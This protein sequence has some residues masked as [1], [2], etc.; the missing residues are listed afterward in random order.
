MRSEAAAGRAAGVAAALGAVAIWAGWIPVTRLGVLTRL[1]PADVA[2]LRYGTA[3]LLL[4]PV[5]APRVRELPWRRPGPLLALLAGAGVPYFL[6]FAYGL[7][8]ANSGQ[9]G[10]LGPG[11]TSA[12]A[13]LLAW[14]L[15]GERPRPRRLAGLALTL[16]GIA[17]V[18]GHDLAAGGG[19]LLG[20][21][22]I[23]CASLGWAAYTVASRVLGLPPVLNAA[24]VAVANA[25][26]FLPLYLAGGG[27]AR[28]AGVPPADF[29]LQVA[30]QGVLTAVVALVA[31]AFAI[32]R[33]G[34]AA[35]ASFTP[36]APVLVALF[37]WL[38]LGDTVDVATAVGLGT[39]AAGV[40][41]A[42]SGAKL[43]GR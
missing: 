4:A 3:A 17:V 30:Y 8:L 6:L 42:N 36:L 20:F 37:G 43:S 27:A 19:R 21:G 15:L 10:V 13:A 28:L 33:L 23:L 9:G 1:T 25:V 29:A 41:V 16:A 24:F 39:V 2:A 40:V 38:I 11:A 34:A 35:A 32:Q 31:F 26:L 5:L 14:S 12:F 7:R 18:V 22:L